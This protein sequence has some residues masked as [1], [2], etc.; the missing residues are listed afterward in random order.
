MGSTR[1]RTVV[2]A[3]AAAL[4]FLDGGFPTSAARAEDAPAAGATRSK[5]VQEPPLEG[6][7][8]K[9][10]DAD[11]ARFD[12]RFQGIKNRDEL[13]Q[14]M[15][16][17]EN[18]GS[19]AARDFLMQYARTVK[20]AEYRG[21]AFDAITKIG[22]AKGIEFLCGKAGVRST[23]SLVQRQAVDALGK[24]GD[25]AAVGALLDTLTDA[26]LKMETL[27]AVCLA[28]GKTAP[29]DA[30]VAEALFSAAAD[31][32]DTVRACAVEALGYVPGDKSFQYILGVLQNDKFA[33]AREGAAK[34]LSHAGKAEAIPALEVAAKDKSQPVKA[35][36][37]QALKDLGA[38]GK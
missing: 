5:P 11:S 17:L 38:T 10:Y 13:L 29:D 7:A 30:R 34:G 31:R 22:G 27:G 26:A 15:N 36:A 9:K 18:D 14:F 8:K 4:A 37:I 23:D 21:R 6:D 33:A 24:A 3:A 16:E 19:R 20:S 35:A 32:R 2:A 28:L 1:R 12:K 25:R